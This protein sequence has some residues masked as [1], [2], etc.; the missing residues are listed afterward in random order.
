VNRSTDDLILTKSIK[1]SLCIEAQKAYDHMI[2]SVDEPKQDISN[3]WDMM[4]QQLTG[5]LCH[6]QGRHLKH[7]PEG[8]TPS[9]LRHV[10][11]AQVLINV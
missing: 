9:W 10:P 11:T 5:S 3:E 6:A 4:D 1:Y 2:T 8:R 7:N